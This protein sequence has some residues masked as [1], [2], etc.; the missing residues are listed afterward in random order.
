MWMDGGKHSDGSRK[1]KD[2]HKKGMWGK[3]KT[4]NNNIYPKRKVH[5]KERK[6]ER[7]ES[8]LRMK[9]IWGHSIWEEEEEEGRG[10]VRF[11]S[12]QIGTTKT[13]KALSVEGQRQSHVLAFMPSHL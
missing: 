2:I 4:K 7:D 6:K 1:K 12:L 3:L 13:R 11:D 9:G 8:G 10:W 5:L